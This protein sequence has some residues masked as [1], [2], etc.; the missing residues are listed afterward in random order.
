[1]SPERPAAAVGAQRARGHR[2]GV[3]PRLP[4]AAMPH[5]GGGAL[6]GSAG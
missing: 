1:M 5:E 4:M 6:S 3:T 2:S